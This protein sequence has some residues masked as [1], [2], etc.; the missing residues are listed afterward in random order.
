MTFL[1]KSIENNFFSR[2]LP[3][4]KNR[5]RQFS[6][7]KQISQILVPLSEHLWIFQPEKKP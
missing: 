6:L 3:E 5:K 7:N 4:K 2:R 1:Y